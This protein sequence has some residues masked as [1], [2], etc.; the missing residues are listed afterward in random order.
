MTSRKIGL[1]NRGHQV[2]PRTATPHAEPA[3]R[4]K[5]HRHCGYCGGGHGRR[6]SRRGV[7]V[8]AA[9]GCRMC[10]WGCPHHRIGRP[11][12]R[13]YVRRPQTL[14]HGPAPAG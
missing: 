8:W 13:C 7:S 4:P 2:V 10:S 6:I 9:P 1:P 14:P 3:C 11:H 12:P 5:G